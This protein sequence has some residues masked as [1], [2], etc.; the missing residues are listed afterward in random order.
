MYNIITLLLLLCAEIPKVLTMHQK[1][2]HQLMEVISLIIIV[3]A[4]N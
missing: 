2:G 4:D 3:I 1:G